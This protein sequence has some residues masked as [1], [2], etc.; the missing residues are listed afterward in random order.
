M[1]SGA[2]EEA[3]RIPSVDSTGR[4]WSRLHSSAEDDGDDIVVIPQLGDREVDEDVRR[5]FERRHSVTVPMRGSS[6]DDMESRRDDGR[7]EDEMD[8]DELDADCLSSY[9]PS[10]AA[11][12]APT[13]QTQPSSA[14]A[15]S[16]LSRYDPARRA[17]LLERRESSSPYV[18]RRGSSQ[19]VRRRRTGADSSSDAEIDQDLAGMCF[20]PSGEYVYVGA[21][22]G[23]AEWKIRGAEQRWWSEPSFA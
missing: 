5:L 22:H 4:R 15:S 9:S 6:L 8:V 2:L 11:S 3:F 19:A 21:V 7:P 1:F 20:D 10:R 17:G 23:I 13:S 14:P 18:T 16:S 12:P